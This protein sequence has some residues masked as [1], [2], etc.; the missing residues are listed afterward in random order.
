LLRQC[1]DS[2]QFSRNFDNNNQH[3]CVEFIQSVFEH[4]WNNSAIP[5][6]LKENIFGGLSQE[7]LS[8]K[9]GHTEELP[10]NNMP[11]IL[12]IAVKGV[13]IQ[14]CLANYFSDE[15]VKW[16]CPRCLESNASKSVNIIQEPET[17]LLQLMRFKCSPLDGQTIKMHNQVICPIDLQL[18]SD[19]IYTLKCII[20]HIG[21][22]PQ[23][24]HYNSLLCEKISSEFVLID[25]DVIKSNVK[26]DR[27]MRKLPY[28][29]A[30]VKC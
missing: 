10:V 9:C 20:N 2:G 3:D 8:C 12:P 16:K 30:Y 15:T 1:F 11:E 18:N 23:S 6:N 29:V 21:S 19:T 28:L 13:N 24:G 5:L 7:V 27:E 25:D 22:S 14:T 4:L 17:L 26:I